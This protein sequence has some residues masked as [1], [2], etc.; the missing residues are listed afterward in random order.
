MHAHRAVL[1]AASPVLRAML[2]AGMSE[3]TPGAVIR[4]GGG[5]TAAGVAAFLRFLYLRDP[6]ALFAAAA[7]PGDKAPAP[8]GLSPPA[9]AAAAE[10]LELA[11]M[12]EVEDLVGPCAAALARGLTADSVVGTLRA[13]HRHGLDALKGRC[14]RLV[15]RDGAQA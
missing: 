1:A 7:L 3:S 10:L 8:P 4:P 15:R 9:A 11:A 6:A 14:L 12:Y 5:A 2:S 13:A